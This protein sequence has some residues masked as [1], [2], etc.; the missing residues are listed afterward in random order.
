MKT[1]FDALLTDL[2]AVGE[3]HKALEKGDEVDDEKIE[4]AK[5][6]GAESEEEGEKGKTEEVAKDVKSGKASGKKAPLA[7]SLT[8]KLEDG[9]EV[10]ALDGTEL[11]KSLTDSLGALTE[12]FDANESVLAKAMPQ[13]VTLLKA[14][15]TL[16]T[17]LQAQVKAI[18]N[19]GRGRK[20]IVSMVEKPSTG[21]LA[22]GGEDGINPDE[23]MAKAT[24]KFN[25][26]KLSGMELSFIEGAFNRGQFQLPPDLVSKVV[27]A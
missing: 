9:S 10:E 27:A 5:A 6:G 20:A 3:L 7:K 11:V 13:L 15:T 1:Q 16:I 23:F 26:R 22:K 8:V 14:Q 2:E 21:T 4:A 24:A 12:R 19:E 17:G 18:G 25:D